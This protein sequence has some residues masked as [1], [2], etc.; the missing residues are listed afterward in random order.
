MLKQLRDETF[1]VLMCV[2]DKS[3]VEEKV[4]QAIRQAFPKAGKIDV[5]TCGSLLAPE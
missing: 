5:A 4:L 1:D 3:Q 2:A